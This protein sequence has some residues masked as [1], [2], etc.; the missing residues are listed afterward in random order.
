MVDMIF[1]LKRLSHPSVV[2][3]IGVTTD[4]FQMVAE[5]TSDRHP[6]EYFEEHPEADRISLVSP[7]LFIALDQSR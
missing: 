1:S 6:M 5:R 4:P 2:S 7:L 3:F